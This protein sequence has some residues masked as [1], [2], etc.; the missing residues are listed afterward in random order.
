VRLR[1]D[2]YA[3]GLLAGF[4]LLGCKSTHSDSTTTSSAALGCADGSCKD[5]KPKA[6][7]TAGSS[8]S[9]C[10]TCATCRAPSLPSAPSMATIAGTSGCATCA[11]KS[12]TILTP[13]SATGGW[14]TGEPMVSGSTSI[15]TVPPILSGSAGVVPANLPPAL[16]PTSPPPLGPGIETVGAGGAPILLPNGDKLIPQSTMTVRFGESNDYGTLVGQVSQFR[17]TWRLRY[18]SVESEDKLGGSVILIGNDLDQLRE[19][20]MV[21]VQGSVLPGDDRTTGTRYQ[22]TH[23][24]LLEPGR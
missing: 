9:S 14:T 3:L 20:Q 1:Y 10:S 21:R 11:A 16:A 2:L 15:A 18:T 17:H 5:S 8:C 7:D 22:V 6:T 4:G 23:F 12:S 19:G 24:D 13:V